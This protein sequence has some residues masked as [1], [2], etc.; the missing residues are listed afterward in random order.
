MNGGTN[1]LLAVSKS[2]SLDILQAFHD[3]F[4]RHS[5]SHVKNITGLVYGRCG[6]LREEMPYLSNNGNWAT[7]TCRFITTSTNTYETFAKLILDYLGPLPKSNKK[8][9][10]L[11]ATDNTR[12][13]GIAKATGKVDAHT[14][15]KVILDDIITCY[16][17][18]REVKTDRGSDF[19]DGTPK[20]L[21]NG[22]GIVYRTSVEYW[23]QSQSVMEQTI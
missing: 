10:I 2:L 9:F 14:R 19:I 5:K 13:F 4:C 15:A 16:G 21:Y 11:V 12:R 18:P 22:L 6:S 20:Q 17:M 7:E 8:L 1:L 23:P 3:L